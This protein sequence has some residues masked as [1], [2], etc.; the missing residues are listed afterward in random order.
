MLRIRQEKRLSEK[1]GET[2]E[3]GERNGKI[4]QSWGE[5]A[6]KNPLAESLGSKR[7]KEILKPD[8]RKQHI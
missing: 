3:K 6:S 7:H 1:R 5:N 2:A 8:N 4:R